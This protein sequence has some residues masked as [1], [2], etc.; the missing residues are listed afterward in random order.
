[1]T[2]ILKRKCRKKL[3]ISVYLVNRSPTNTLKTTPF[4]M[5]KKRKP[6]LKNLQFFGCDAYAKVFGP[7]KKLDKRSKHYIFIGYAPS[8]YRL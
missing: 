3:Y 6:D 8:G 7:L 4:E 1:M 5:W 2:Q